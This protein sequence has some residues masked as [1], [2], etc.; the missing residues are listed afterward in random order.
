M[1][2]HPVLFVIIGPQPAELCRPY[3]AVTKSKRTKTTKAK[4][5]QVYENNEN[6]CQLMEKEFIEKT[7]WVIF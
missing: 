1:I 4:P 6:E 2:S 7:L 3:G 5:I